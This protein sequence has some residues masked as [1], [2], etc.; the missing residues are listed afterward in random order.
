MAFSDCRNWSRPKT[1]GLFGYLMRVQCHWGSVFVP[2]ILYFTV[3]CQ[4]NG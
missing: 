4:G 2:D 1:Q 3:D